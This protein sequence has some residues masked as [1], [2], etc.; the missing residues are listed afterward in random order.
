[1]GAEKSNG[2]IR[3]L[4]SYYDG[5]TFYRDN[6]EFDLTPNTVIITELS[7]KYG[8]MLNGKYQ[9]LDYDVHIYPKDF[10]CPKEYATNKI[11]MTDNTY[12]IHHFNGSW[13]DKKSKLKKAI[14]QKCVNI[15][16]IEYYKK[17]RYFFK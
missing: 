1:M 12:C 7:H 11:K 9:I 10:F 8:L 13:L 14:I 3:E 4:L 16:G 17:I 5:K 15:I 2:W 6:G